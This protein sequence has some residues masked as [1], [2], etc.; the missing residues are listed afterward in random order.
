MA[1]KMYFPIAVQCDNC[2]EELEVSYELD[3]K[4]ATRY[5]YIFTPKWLRN[6]YNE[7]EEEARLSGWFIETNHCYCPECADQL[8]E[9]KLTPKINKIDSRSLVNELK[10]RHKLKQITKEDSHD[11]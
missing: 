4:K 5:R 10:F 11:N 1:I 6:I 9:G 8:E 3:I 7:L 2:S